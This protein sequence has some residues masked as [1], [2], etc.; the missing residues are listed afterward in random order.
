[1]GQPVTKGI[2]GTLKPRTFADY[3]DE[4]EIARGGQGG[5][6][7]VVDTNLLRPLAMKLLDPELSREESNRKRFVEEAQ[8]TAQLDHPNIPAVHRLDIDGDGQLFFTMKLLP[9][10]TFE[11]V[12]AAGAHHGDWKELFRVLQVFVTVCNA[13]A[14]AHAR[15][16]VHRDLK[17]ENIMVA[18]R[19][20]VYVMDWGIARVIGHS[21]PSEQGAKPQVRV[22]SAASDEEGTVAGTPQYMAPEQALGSVDG[23]DARTD[24]F[25]LGAILYHLVVGKAPY[26]APTAI[27]ILMKAAL[28]E[29]AP[30]QAVAPHR[31][32]DALAAVVMRAMSKDPA[33]RYQ[34]VDELREEIE[35]FMRGPSELPVRSFAAGEVIVREGDAADCAYVIVRGRARVYKTVAGRQVAIRELGPG[36]AFGEAAIFSAHP[37][38]ATVEATEPLV[39]TVVTRDTLE[40]ELGQAS[41]VAPLVRQLASTFRAID[42]DLTLRRADSTTLGMARAALLYAAKH[43][44]DAGLGVNAVAWSAL[45]RHLCK[46]FGCGD[47]EATACVASM[48]EAALDVAGDVVRIAM[49]HY[50]A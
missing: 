1:M 45:R 46:A 21:R 49:N 28:C 39:A 13:V 16:V 9:G 6:R 14:F 44:R 12:L 10:T 26:D 5:I 25:A 27:A 24:V 40:Q 48:P 3:V 34:S 23:I 18:D 4:G 36:A 19:G 2:T 33:D 7:R 11:D 47:A 50:G 15:G 35:T 32:P 37:R 17:P 43:G 29:Y 30:P 22:W 41:M 31:V 20:Q 42:E 8:I 38:S